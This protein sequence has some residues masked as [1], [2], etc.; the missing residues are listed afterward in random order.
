MKLYL[1][2]SV[3]CRIMLNLCSIKIAFWNTRESEVYSS[4][5]KTLLQ[6]KLR[7]DQLFYWDPCSKLCS[8][9]PFSLY[10]LKSVFEDMQ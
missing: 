10:F 9:V 7:W 6:N 4:Y 1:T 3:S 8:E 2:V 5:G